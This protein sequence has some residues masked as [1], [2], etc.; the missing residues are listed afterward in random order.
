MIGR[1]DL[2]QAIGELSEERLEQSEQVEVRQSK[3]RII[4]VRYAGIVA[5]ACL[6]LVIGIAVPTI[7]NKGR[8]SF[9]SAMSEGAMG[10]S[11]GKGKGLLETSGVY[12]N[13]AAPEGDDYM[14][15]AA[16][17]ADDAMYNGDVDSEEALESQYNT[18]SVPTG[19]ND[20]VYDRVG[21]DQE[22]RFLIRSDGSDTQLQSAVT[23]SVDAYAVY[24]AIPD[25]ERK[26]MG[27]A[28][29]K[30]LTDEDLGSYLGVTGYPESNEDAPEDIAGYK[31]YSTAKAPEDMTYVIVDL[32]GTYKLCY[33]VGE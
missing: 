1:E 2:F 26:R 21:T 20:T 11:D 18:N 32:N 8:G 9:D 28:E 17:A 5:A 27:Y 3:N 16:P 23:E 10:Q 25:V 24:E 33:K 12:T 7:V 29:D 31:V 30:D 22:F 4:W 6:I 19:D 15:D 13:E 14:D